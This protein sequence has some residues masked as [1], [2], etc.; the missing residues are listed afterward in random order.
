MIIRTAKTTPTKGLT[1][2][3][4][5]ISLLILAI[6]IGALL[7]TFVIGRIGAAKA[8]HRLVAMNLCRARMEWTKEQ[9]SATLAGLAGSGSSESDVA[10]AE[11]LSDTRQTQV[12][13]DSD[14]NFVVTVTMQWTEQSWG[15]SNSASEE[16]VSVINRR[17]A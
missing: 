3:E 11:L 4:S 9:P 7:G 16:L 1:L 15:G 14:M 6:T 13:L 5:V 2:V 12:T 8:R 17:G 10:G